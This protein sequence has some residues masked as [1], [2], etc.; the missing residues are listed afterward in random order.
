M[1][2]LLNVRAPQPC[3]GFDF[4]HLVL[5]ARDRLDGA[6][7]ALLAMGFTLTPMAHHN[8][9]S[10]NRLAVLEGAYLELL[11]WDP[12]GESVRKEIANEPF[13]LNALVFRTW[14]A[15]ACHRRLQEGGFQ[16]N[17]VQDLS[18]PTTIDGNDVVARFKT[19]R[20]SEQPVSGLRIYFC[21]HLTPEYI[22]RSAYMDHANTLCRLKEVVVAS[23]QPSDCYAR[24][25][26]LVGLPAADAHADA[27]RD[28]DRIIALGSCAIRV[29]DAEPGRP[30]HISSC[31][32]ASRDGALTTTLNKSHLGW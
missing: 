3:A 18:R 26:A 10:I 32:I 8:V 14:D 5:M 22:W 27:V 11:G 13:G 17:P 4:D 6:A 29:V 19:V 16:P 1:S 28:G 20:F 2:H 21:E 23:A 30:T 12:G 15:H 31:A 9:G 7:Q 25:M 24:L